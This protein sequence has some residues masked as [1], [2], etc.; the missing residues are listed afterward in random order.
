MRQLTLPGTLCGGSML[1]GPNARIRLASVS[2]VALFGI[3][4]AGCGDDIPA[5]HDGGTGGSGGSG[6][7]GGDAGV[8]RT[9]ADAKV[10]GV[11]AGE[12]GDVPTDR[13]EGGETGD[14]PTDR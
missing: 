12:T 14:V 13:A 10:D 6:G 5:Q 4:A 7:R 9:D 1:T 11:E 2:L 3:L 8:D